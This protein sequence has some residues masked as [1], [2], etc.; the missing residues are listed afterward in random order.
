MVRRWDR[1][2]NPWDREY[3]KRGRLWRGAAS[4]DPLP[5]Y[6]SPPA[7]VLDVGCGDGKFA[8]ALTGAGYDWVGLDF[9]RHALRLLPQGSRGVLG[10][11]RRLPFRDASFPAVVARYT[12][13]ALSEKGRAMAG[14]ELARVCAPNGTILVEE[15]SVDDFRYGKGSQVEA[16]T[17]ERNQGLWTHYFTEA[18]I[19]NLVPSREAVRVDV[20]RRRLRILGRSHERVSLRAVFA[21]SSNASKGRGA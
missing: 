1:W 2:K 15:F 18:E 5:E 3:A 12:L 7:L 9:S 11:A 17:F 4:I 14:K 10:D 20:M 8:A 19:R 21:A 6:V 13:G 16:G